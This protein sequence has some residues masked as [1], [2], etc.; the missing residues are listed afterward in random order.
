M[1]ATRKRTRVEV[2]PSDRLAREIQAVLSDGLIKPEY[3]VDRSGRAG[4]DGHC[5]HAAEA[6]RYLSPRGH[7]LTVMNR[8]DEEHSH[9]WLVDERGRVI[10]LTYGPDDKRSRYQYQLG[11]ARTFLK[12]KGR[13]G[14]SWRAEEVV[15][16]VERARGRRR[17]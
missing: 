1:M 11:R 4:Y 5:Y 16:R 15:E 17:R 6:Y 2:A 9:W 13:D 7:A 14:L 10:D 8:K 12:G 3:Q